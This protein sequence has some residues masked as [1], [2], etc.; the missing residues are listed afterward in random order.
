MAVRQSLVWLTWSLA[1]VL[2][3]PSGARAR[4]NGTARELPSGEPDSPTTTLRA[5]LRCYKTADGS[6]RDPAKA[7]LNA[8]FLRASTPTLTSRSP[9]RRADHCVVNPTAIAFVRG[10][11]LAASRMMVP[12]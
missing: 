2:Q 9:E 11:S 6:S 7:K 3:R 5:T 12:S 8:P 1:L 4:L 10:T